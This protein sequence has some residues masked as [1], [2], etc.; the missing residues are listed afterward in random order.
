MIGRRSVLGGRGPA[1]VNDYFA[2]RL[3]RGV[4]N[5]GILTSILIGALSLFWILALGASVS[6]EAA[7]PSKRTVPGSFWVILMVS[8]LAVGGAHQLITWLKKALR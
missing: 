1:R 8:V 5:V 3:L 6:P 2:I 4:M 7:D